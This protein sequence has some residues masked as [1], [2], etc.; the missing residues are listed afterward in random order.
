MTEKEPETPAG[1]RAA[2]TLGERGAVLGRE[3]IIQKQISQASVQGV[4]IAGKSVAL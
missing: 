4:P 2:Q 3:L 1:S